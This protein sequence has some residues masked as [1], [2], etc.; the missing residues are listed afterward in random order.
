VIDG[1]FAYERA[2]E[3]VEAERLGEFDQLIGR[4]EEIV[5]DGGARRRSAPPPPRRTSSL[6][7]ATRLNRRDV[8]ERHRAVVE[9]IRQL[10]MEKLVL[11]H[12]LDPNTPIVRRPIS[13][14]PARPPAKTNAD[15]DAIELVGIGGATPRE[16]RGLVGRS[17]FYL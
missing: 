3:A 10:T 8:E 4:L 2:V 5:I 13:E 16:P 15:Q 12:M 7:P 6:S 11:E 14:S 1:D 17:R 9:E